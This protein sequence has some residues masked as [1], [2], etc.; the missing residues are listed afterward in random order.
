MTTSFKSP[1]RSSVPLTVFGAEKADPLRLDCSDETVFTVGAAVCRATCCGCIMGLYVVYPVCCIGGSTQPDEI[2]ARQVAITGG[3]LKAL[4][5]VT[6]EVVLK[7][8]SPPVLMRRRHR[9]VA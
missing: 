5:P 1:E 4:A 8:Q 2:I 7:T 9:Q 3:H 6:T